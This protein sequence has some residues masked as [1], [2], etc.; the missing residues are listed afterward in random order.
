M[1]RSEAY[2]LGALSIFVICAVGK[3][4]GQV[5]FKRAALYPKEN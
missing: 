5:L 2:A 3:V 4:A 1:S